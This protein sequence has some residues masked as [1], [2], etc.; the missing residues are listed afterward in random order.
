MT[1]SLRF[2]SLRFSSLPGA[3]KLFKK[4]DKSGDGLLDARELATMIRRDLKISKSDV[5][6]ADIKVHTRDDGPFLSH[7]ERLPSPPKRELSSRT[8][9]TSRG[10]NA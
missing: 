7:T 10:T 4:F 9:P 3:K 2:A 8:L 1:S 5:S 6:D